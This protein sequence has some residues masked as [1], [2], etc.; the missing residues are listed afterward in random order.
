[1]PFKKLQEATNQPMDGGQG[2][3]YC[4]DQF[5]I[6]VRNAPSIASAIMNLQQLHSMSLVNTMLNEESFMILLNAT[7]KTLVSLNLSENEHL[8]PK[9]YS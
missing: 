2:L 1:M 7:P 8:S 5:S 4:L 3:K 9:C 6:N